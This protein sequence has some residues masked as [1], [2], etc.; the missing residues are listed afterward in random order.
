MYYMVLVIVN[1]LEQTP[2]LLD[3]WEA[4]AV[5]GITILE[6]TGLGK[7]RKAGL[8][9]DMPLIPSLSD[10]FRTQEHRHRT[11]F[12][13]V[14]GEAKVDELIAITQENLGDMEQPE[15]GVLFVLPVSRVIGLQGAQ[16]RARRD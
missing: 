7:I 1:N 3:A 10:L 4:A 5:P 9:D 6:S 11:I 16:A 2:P 12:T 13:V 15:N 8:R 14:E